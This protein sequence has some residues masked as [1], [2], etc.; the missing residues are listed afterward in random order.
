MHYVISDIH[1][2]YAQFTELLELIHFKDTDILYVLGDIVDRGPHPIKVL[3]ALM[4]MP[5]VVCIVGNHEL[6]ALDGL[7]FLNTQI[8]NESIES[9]DKETMGNLFNWIRNGGQTTIDEFKSLP[10]VK[11]QEIID[12]IM[13]FSVYEEPTVNGQQFLLIHAGLGNY[14]PEKSIEDYSLQNLVWDRN[15][16]NTR[17]F[18]DVTVIT[19]HT[20]TQ[21]IKGNRKLGSVFRHLNNIAIDCGCYIPGGRLAAICLETGEEF[22]SSVNGENID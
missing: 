7:R 3:S 16:Y 5:N 21:L 6:M 18:E 15:D 12:F 20:P 8:T 1:G 2:C 17:Y 10:P 19:G 22:Y 11:R 13:D 9:M 14:A 4:E